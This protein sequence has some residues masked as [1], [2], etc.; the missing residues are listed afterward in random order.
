[1]ALEPAT[2]AK[3]A[4][5]ACKAVKETTEDVLKNVSLEALQTLRQQAQLM[6]SVLD[7]AI[8]KAKPCRY[9]RATVERAIDNH[10]I[11]STDAGAR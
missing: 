8:L 2:L 5:I 9:N 10:R 11:V 3:N 6:V 7:L 1:M 4:E